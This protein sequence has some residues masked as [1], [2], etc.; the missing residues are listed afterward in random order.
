LIFGAL[1]NSIVFMQPRRNEIKVVKLVVWF[2]VQV[3]KWWY[4]WV[5]GS[6]VQIAPNTRVW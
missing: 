4:C 2:W 5:F 3:K 1:M 6:W